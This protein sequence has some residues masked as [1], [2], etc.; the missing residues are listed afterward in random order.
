MANLIGKRY[1]YALFEAGLELNKLERFKD[2]ITNIANILME[3]D[4][5]KKILSHPKVSKGEKKEL[6][7][8][9]FKDLISVEVLNFLYILVDKRREKSILE[10]NKEFIKLYN[11][12]ENIA[13][14]TVV[15]SVTM[16]EKAKEKLTITLQ[17][18]L[19]KKIKLKNIVDKDIIGGVLLKIGNKVIDGTVKGQL[20]EIEKA[21]KGA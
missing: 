21:I 11:E 12:H 14:V 18:R 17:K 4:N 10:I 13:E 19:N 5:F 7:N 15:T 9:V 16:N 3:E 1:A 8:N 20:Q 6:L 2:D